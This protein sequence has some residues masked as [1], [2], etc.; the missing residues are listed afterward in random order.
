MLED[1]VKKHTPKK[2]KVSDEKLQS[3]IKWQPHVAQSPIIDAYNAGRRFIV[4]NAGR[5][6]G[7]SNFC[8]YIALKKL[9]EPGKN[10]WIVS[11][12]YDLSQKVFNYLVRYFSL[13]APSQKGNITNRPYPKIRTAGQ[14]WVECKSAENP[15]ALLGE[16]LDLLIIDEASRIPR[17]VWEQYLFPTLSS[18]RGT[19]IFISTP[20]GKNWFFEEA[21]KAKEEGAY[22]HFESIDNPHFSREEWELAKGKLPED[23]FNQEYR[24]MFL[25]DAAAVFKG[26]HDIV[27]D[28]TLKEPEPGHEYTMGVD[29]ARHHDFTVLT[30]VDTVTNHLVYFERFNKIDYNLQKERIKAVAAKY[31][32]RVLIDSTGVGDPIVEDLQRENVMV[33]DFAFTQKSKK[34]LIEKLSIFI[35]QKWLL[36][37]PIEQLIDELEAFGYV[38][39]DGGNIK[40]SAPSGY[41]DDCVL[42]LALAVWNLNG[43]PT[44][45]P[46]TSPQEYNGLGIYTQTYS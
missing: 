39:S 38:M 27:F 18:R 26:I 17:R 45:T 3:I 35:Q 29:L 14:S 37:P 46:T 1:V 23:V 44:N 22:F 2:L 8:A 31:A 25:D 11:P 43:E 12:T 42:S 32:A 15:T 36:I 30:V 4:I 34:N 41:K 5:R 40:Y 6:F 7:K 19:A 33:D 21:M 16:E 9:L 10:I 24:A 20:K 28:T 13:V